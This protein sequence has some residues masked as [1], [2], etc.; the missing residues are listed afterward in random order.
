MNGLK[1]SSPYIRK[2]NGHENLTR[3]MFSFLYTANIAASNI[4]LSMVSLP[5][6]QIVRST[7]PALTVL[8]ERLWLGKKQA[9][10]KYSSL[11]L[12]IAGVCIA[13]LGELDFSTL[14]FVL[15]IIGVFLSSI[16]GIVTNVIL[17]GNLKLHPLD[18]LRRMAM[19]S[20]FQC[21]LISYLSGELD[22]YYTFYEVRHQGNGVGMGSWKLDTE[23]DS[24]VFTPGESFNPVSDHYMFLAL[25][26]NGLLAF[27]LNAIS[28][29]SNKRTS[30]LSMTVAGNVKQAMSI[31][32]S[33]VLFSYAVS[34]LN[35]FGIILTL[36]GGAW[37]SAIGLKEKGSRKN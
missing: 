37:Y 30:A 3:V 9:A 15:T 23:S 36:I 34:L 17:V 12:V 27:L 29:I 2:L 28:F 20:F 22:E 13:T 31:L 32:L 33:M 25:F 10:E 16:K 7:N 6:H 24:W 1:V 35:G 21:I 5:F 11:A 4:S 26:M 19:L 18:L 8:F 14:G